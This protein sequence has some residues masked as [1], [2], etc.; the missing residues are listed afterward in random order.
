MCVPNFLERFPEQVELER[1]EQV[2]LSVGRLDPVKGFDRLIRCFAKIHERRPEWTL[3]LVGEGSER[4]KLET[5]IRENGLEGAVCLTGRLDAAGVETEMRRASLYA[6]ASH[7]EG[8]GIVLIEAQSCG[9]PVVAFDVR[10]GPAAVVTDGVDGY[11]VPDG[12]E[13][14]YAERL[15]EL[16]EREDLRRE[17]ALR[18]MEQ[19]RRFSRENVARIWDDILGE[20]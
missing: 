16:M 15:L 17:M 2:L 7:S 6:M 5:L 8:F 1:K 14:R 11:L 3:R 13:E 10:V 9:L 18:A 19:V 4:A 20:E 12:N